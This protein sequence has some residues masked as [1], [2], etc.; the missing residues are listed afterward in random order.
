M[1]NLM[2]VL[3]QVYLDQIFKVNLTMCENIIQK[4]IIYTTP[5]LKEC[6]ILYSAQPHVFKLEL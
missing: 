2:N 1:S 5:N 3:I 4:F 6:N